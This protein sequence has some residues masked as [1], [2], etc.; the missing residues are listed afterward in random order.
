M[1]HRGALVTANPDLLRAALEP[2]ILDVIAAGATY[3]YEIAKAIQA[4]S[5]GQLLAQEGTLYPA[6]HRL[7]TRGYLAAT[8]KESP[9]GRRRKHYALT[10]AGR[11]R[12]EALRAQWQSFS[13]VVSRI[14]GT[15]ASHHAVAAG[16]F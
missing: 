7:E 1:T 8:W 4:A 11:R 12:L 9:E 2:V 15:E 3:G 14:L 16:T 13:Q 10:A 6:L 5:G